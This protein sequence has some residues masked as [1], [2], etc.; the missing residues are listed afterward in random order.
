MDELIEQYVDATK[1][2]LS[3]KEIAD[4]YS[5]IP[6]ISEDGE[7]IGFFALQ[8]SKLEN[9]GELAIVEGVY[10]DPD[11]AGKGLRFYLPQLFMSLQDMGIEWVQGNAEPVIAKFLERRYNIKP[12]SMRYLEPIQKLTGRIN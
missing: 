12:Q 3:A 2:V 9:L 11:R 4:N 6:I 10:L 7:E 1:S 5:L 8:F